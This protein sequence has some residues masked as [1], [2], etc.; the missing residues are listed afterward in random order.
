[1]GYY[2]RRRLASAE[3]IVSLDV[4]LCV[5]RAATACRISLGGEGY[6][7]YPV[8]FSWP[9]AGFWIWGGGRQQVNLGA[10]APLIVPT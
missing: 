8:I 7:L 2:L 4:R 6:A 5:L 3:G 9:L 10:R 1:M